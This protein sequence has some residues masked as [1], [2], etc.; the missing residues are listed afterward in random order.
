M[1][2]EDAAG[3]GMRSPL[4]GKRAI[5]IEDEGVTQLQI[6]RALT[7]AGIEIAG[8]ALNARAGIDL[9][10]RERPDLVLM[11]I[12]MPG[13]IDGLDAAAAIL[14][15]FRVCIVI[16]TAADN[17][18]R[19][20]RAK[21]VGACAYLVKPIL[22]QPLLQELERSYDEWT[23]GVSNEYQNVPPCSSH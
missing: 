16:V 4:A 11:D 1:G 8:V 20:W 21:K 19:R 23:R 18:E 15:T 3:G 2:A 9:V 10:L 5:V 12:S 13:D 14:A 7:K 22:S 17:D 6:R